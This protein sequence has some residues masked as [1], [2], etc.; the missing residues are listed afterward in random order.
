MRIPANRIHLANRNALTVRQY[1]PI[2]RIARQGANEKKKC[3]TFA[4][5]IFLAS[6]SSRGADLNRALVPDGI[7]QRPQLFPN[8]I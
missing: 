3:A 2:T 8:A 4:Y 6:D 5:N 1:L 7:R